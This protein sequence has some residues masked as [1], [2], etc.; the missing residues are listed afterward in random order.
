[1]NISRLRYLQRASSTGDEGRA[2]RRVALVEARVAKGLADK[3]GRRAAIL[4]V[5]L[6][7]LVGANTGE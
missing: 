6:N 2:D 4:I 3:G 7:L 5:N 1:V